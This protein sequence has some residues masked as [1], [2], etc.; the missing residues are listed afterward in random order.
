VLAAAVLIYGT[1]AAAGDNADPGTAFSLPAFLYQLTDTGGW[2][3]KLEQQGLKLTFSY[4][5]DAFAN[6]IGGVKQG[7]GYD[8]RFGT[9]IDADLE[10]LAGWPGATFHASI[11]QIHGTQFSAAN[12]DTLMVVSGIE[13]PNSTRL[14]NLWIEQEFSNRFNLRVGQ[15]TAAQEFLVSDNADLF[16]NS[17]FGWP[18][19]AAAD[20]P[21]GGPNYPEATPGARL[22]IA[23]ADHLTFRAAIF[24]GNPAG[25]GLGNPVSRD[26]YGLAFRVRDPPFV[27]AE[28]EYEYGRPAPGPRAAV[29]DPNQEATLWR[30]GCGRRAA[31]RFPEQ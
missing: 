13:A 23:V 21:S 27:I 7:F 19:L 16:I 8:G 11:H 26:P 17:T 31:H 2:R 24:D 9:I 29:L 6:P 1:A 14:F 4:Y 28:F 20:L 12:L 22:Q 25:P 30:Q 10:N 18:L 5:G 15:F 3:S